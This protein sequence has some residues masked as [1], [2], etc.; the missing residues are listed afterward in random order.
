MCS[1]VVE[2]HAYS[3][4][5]TFTISV[6]RYNHCHSRYFL[7]V[8]LQVWTRVSRHIDKSSMQWD[9]WAL[10]S[11]RQRWWLVSYLMPRPLT[12]VEWN[13]QEWIIPE[14]LSNNTWRLY[15]KGDLR[16]LNS[17]DMARPDYKPKSPLSLLLEVFSVSLVDASAI[18]ITVSQSKW[19]PSPR[20]RLP[21][22]HWYP[23]TVSFLPIEQK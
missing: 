15:S 20:I 22:V 8:P 12:P 19:V 4:D 3:L 14:H 18:T 7:Q 10:E 23:E 6:S 5:L 17:Y 1:N 21:V 11:R 2:G 13:E 9:V 16:K